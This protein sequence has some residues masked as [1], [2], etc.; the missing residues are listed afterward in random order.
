MIFLYKAKKSL[1]EVV[2]G[3]IDGQN[4]EQVLKNYSQGGLHLY[5]LNRSWWKSPK[6]F[7]GKIALSLKA[8]NGG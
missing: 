4:L 2:E 1:N 6:R 7:L 5:P 8:G 3:R